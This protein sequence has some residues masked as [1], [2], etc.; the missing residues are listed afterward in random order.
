M[1]Y[2]KFA[3]SQLKDISLQLSA[4]ITEKMC[5]E[6][7]DEKALEKLETRLALIADELYK[8]EKAELAAAA[9]RPPAP[10][11]ATPI[12]SSGTESLA[13]DMRFA[14]DHITVFGPGQDAS[15]FIA[16][17]T[18]VHRN[19]VADKPELEGRFTKFAI[20][21]LC[22]TYQTQLHSSAEKVLTFAGLKSFINKHYACQETVYQRLEAV[23]SI[24]IDTTCANYSDNWTNYTVKLEN[25]IND[26]YRYIEAKWK[27]EKGE[28][29]LTNKQLMSIMGT[30]IFLTKLQSSG[31]GAGI[32]AYNSI[33]SQLDGVWN[34]GACHARAKVYL[35]RANQ[36]DILAT[37]QPDQAAF[38][39]RQKHNTRSEK[40]SIREGQ[41]RQDT[42]SSTSARAPKVPKWFLKTHKGYCWRFNSIGK[43]P[44]DPCKYKHLSPTATETEKDAHYHATD[45]PEVE[46][47]FY[48]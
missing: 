18:N 5:A 36:S 33:I 46:Q 21:R 13:K 25:A 17:L 16:T 23:H 32:N 24:Q 6:T 47:G 2:S 28:Q 19:Y 1:D 8:R 10:P 45:E 34:I 37:T 42:A 35:D 31:Q 7:V 44:D 12:T 9:A 27:E 39:S 3:T 15:N 43:C 26:V 4:S 40:E 30:Q 20:T 29:E 11:N 22:D 48:E 38:F 41:P 14:M